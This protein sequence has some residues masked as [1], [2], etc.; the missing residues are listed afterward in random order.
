MDT[1]TY[2]TVARIS[3]VSS[4]LLFVTMFAAIVIYVVFFANRDKLERAQRNA[5]DLGNDSKNIGGLS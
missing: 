3:M 4:L 5:L 2:D 1:L